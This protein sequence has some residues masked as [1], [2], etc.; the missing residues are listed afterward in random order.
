MERILLLLTVLIFTKCQ[1]SKKNPTQ[2]NNNAIVII[3]TKV[4]DGMM[5]DLVAFMDS[6]N[7]LPVTRKLMKRRLMM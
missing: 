1:Q 5:S 2:N 3:T 6:E 7:V 4:K